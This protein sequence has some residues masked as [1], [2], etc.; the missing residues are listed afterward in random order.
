MKK[1]IVAL[2]ILSALMVGIF[3]TV[4]AAAQDNDLMVGYAKMDINPYVYHYVDEN[5]EGEIPLEIFTDK[6]GRE[7]YT[8][9]NQDAKGNTTCEL[10]PVPLR[11]FR[12]PTERLCLPYKMDDNGDGLINQ[13]D[14]VGGLYRVFQ[15]Q[16]EKFG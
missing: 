11:G 1:R 8:N 14:G 15:L 10:M 12:E 6:N 5:R 13:E 3:S 4:A 16:S 2:L 7:Y 9:W